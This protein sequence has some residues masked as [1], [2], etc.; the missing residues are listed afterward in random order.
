M[1][2]PK[3]INYCQK[4]QDS[5]KKEKKSTSKS[6]TAKKAK[7]PKKKKQFPEGKTTFTRKIANYIQSNEQELQETVELIFFIEEEAEKNALYQI[8]EKV[9][10]SKEFTLLKLPELVANLK[11]R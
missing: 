10:R 7:R 6:K 11:K 2:F 5:S 4:I 9:G 8:L 1:V 3:K